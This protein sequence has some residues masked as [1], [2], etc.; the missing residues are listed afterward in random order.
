MWTQLEGA[1]DRRHRR[2]DD[3]RYVISCS[4]QGITMAGIDPWS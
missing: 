2:I 3:P 4:T 1:R